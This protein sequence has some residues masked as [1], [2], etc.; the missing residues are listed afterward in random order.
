MVEKLG[1]DS[2]EE[3]NLN[4]SSI[5][6]DALDTK[7]YY[8][9]IC[10]RNNISK[11]L[12]FAVPAQEQSNVE[13]QNAALGVLTQIISLY[14]DRKKE[15]KRKNSEDNN[16]EEDATVQQN[17]DEEGEECS[18]ITLIAGNIP[19][20]VSYLEQQTAQTNLLET[21]YD[22]KIV[23]L[24]SLRLKLIELM[25]NLIKLNKDALLMS[26]VETDFFG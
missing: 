10:K 22:V 18:L 12:D 24:G 13:S 19:R 4:A 17:S 14:T 26:L 11:L 1:P 15:G 5:L 21:S 25:F 16:E 8:G 3:D 23:P 20:I 6:Q 9:I 7:E 2:S